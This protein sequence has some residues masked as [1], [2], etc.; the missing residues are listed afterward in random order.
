MKFHCTDDAV[1]RGRH[2]STQVTAYMKGFVASRSHTTNGTLGCIF[3]N[4][5]GT[6]LNISNQFWP[7]TTQII[8][9]LSYDHCTTLPL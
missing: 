7:K 4:R 9:G 3:I 1:I 6:I 2:L 5:E 8:Y